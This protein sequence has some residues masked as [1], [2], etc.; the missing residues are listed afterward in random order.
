MRSL[1]FLLPLLLVL[2][3]WTVPVLAATAAAKSFR[4]PFL[5]SGK[6]SPSTTSFTGTSTSNALPLS[7]RGGSADVD[8]A[9]LVEQ[10]YGWATN[11]GAPAALVAGAV[12]ATLYETLSSGSLDVNETTDAKW[13]QVAK[14]ATR[15]LLVSAFMMQIICIFC[16]TVLGTQLI[17]APPLASKA[18]TS[19]QYLQEHYEF[20]VLTAKISFL[21]GLLTWLAAIAV[22]HAI[23]QDTNEPPNRR[24][25]D[26]LIA[27]SLTTLIIAMLSFYNGHM[28]FYNN[29]LHM[30]QRYATVVVKKYFGHWPPKALTILAV[31]SSITSIIFFC[32]VFLMHDGNTGSN[33]SKGKQL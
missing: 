26:M 25:M 3:S 15:M 1:V 5:L 10:A 32:K 29:Y 27:S 21:Q 24:N 17:S 7:L 22:E 19:I 23:P 9:Q 6:T 4:P 30:L 11:L 2:P 28:N 16:T 20:E 8:T 13:V 14:K 18:V 31:P 33:K 12:I